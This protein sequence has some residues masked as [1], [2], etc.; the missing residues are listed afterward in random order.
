MDEH[1]QNTPIDRPLLRSD[2]NDVRDIVQE[3]SQ[4]QL[5]FLDV[6]AKLSK[7]VDTADLRLDRVERAIERK[8]WLPALVG[9][10]AAALAVLARIAP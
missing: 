9:M 10:V 6:N 8:L 7:R 1:E 2:I 4:R 3:I 5:Q